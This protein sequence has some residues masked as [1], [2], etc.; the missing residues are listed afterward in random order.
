MSLRI[1]VTVGA[2]GLATSCVAQHRNIRDGTRQPVVPLPVRPEHV[3]VVG[4]GVVGVTTAYALAR[5]GCAVTLVEQAPDVAVGCSFA[6][7]G[8]IRYS[9]FH[10][11][12]AHPGMPRRMSAYVLARA[13]SMGD[14][15]SKLKGISQEHQ[16]LQFFSVGM[17]S[18]LDP[19][20]YVW[21]ARFLHHCWFTPLAPRC[22]ALDALALH[23]VALLE[24][25]VCEEGMESEVQLQRVGSL[26]VFRR[27]EDFQHAI[28][29][30]QRAAERGMR[31]PVRFLTHAQAIELEPWLARFTPC[32]GAVYNVND[33]SGDCR[34]FVLG[35]ARRCVEKLN[36]RLHLNTAV[37]RTEERG[38]KVVVHLEPV[39]QA[40]EQ[41]QGQAAPRQ[42]EAD[43]LVVCTGRYVGRSAVRAGR[44]AQTLPPTQ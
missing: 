8:G 11:P 23:S 30:A 41:G 31:Q 20:F 21:G 25:T 3:I 9:K 7:A 29:S 34:K 10:T 40:A 26:N 13:R 37:T 18:W 14:A 43:A 22:Q 27:P 24:R 4:A 5:R 17:S 16:P 1:V 36:V 35:L 32:A 6:N 33:L 28:G 2:L 38:D 19:V 39:G 44:P 15:S 42:L 12:M